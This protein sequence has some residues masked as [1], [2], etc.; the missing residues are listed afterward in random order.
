[1]YDKS[2][3]DSRYMIGAENDTRGEIVKSAK[4]GLTSKL[5]VV[6]DEPEKLDPNH[7][8]LSVSSGQAPRHP[9]RGSQAIYF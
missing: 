2:D 7:R 8:P 9:R 4:W 6:I 1:M 3:D 5:N